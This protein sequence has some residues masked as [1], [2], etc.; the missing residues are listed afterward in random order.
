[1][2]GRC[3]S[4]VFPCQS[5]ITRL[6]ECGIDVKGGGRWIRRRAGQHTFVV[7][8]KEE[9]A[10]A[11]SGLE[12]SGSLPIGP[13]GR[14]GAPVLVSPRA[15]RGPPERSGTG[16]VRWR[17]HEA[18]ASPATRWHKNVLRRE[19]SNVW[20]FRGEPSARIRSS[21]FRDDVGGLLTDLQ[22][23]PAPSLSATKRC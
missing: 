20:R 1:M 22:R 5:F 9:M 10:T 19:R 8:V 12:P 16:M 6:V 23:W 18:S 4:Q 11:L 21:S 13:Q 7:K 3:P 15:R 2:A 14:S 17:P